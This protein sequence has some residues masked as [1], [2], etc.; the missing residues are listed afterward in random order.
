MNPKKEQDINSADSGKGTARVLALVS[1][2]LFVSLLVSG[3]CC[4]RC[5]DGN[6]CE[7]KQ[8][9]KASNVFTIDSQT[10]GN[11]YIAPLAPS[12]ILPAAPDS[13][14]GKLRAG[15]KYW[16]PVDAPFVVGGYVEDMLKDRLNQPAGRGFIGKVTDMNGDAATVDFGRGYSAGIFLKEL[17][18]VKVM[19]GSGK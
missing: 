6:C 19:D 18:P 12:N 8:P 10:V 11:R 3:C 13:I 9:C 2:L 15:G 14:E 7:R 1:V 17:R 16:K 5:S 4:C